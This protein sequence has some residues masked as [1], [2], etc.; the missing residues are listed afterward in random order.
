MSRVGRTGLAFGGTGG[1]GG[2]GGLVPLWPPDF[3]HGSSSGGVGFV[4]VGMLGTSVCIT[5]MMQSFIS[6]ARPAT[7]RSISAFCFGSIDLLASVAH[8]VIDVDTR[9]MHAVSLHAQISSR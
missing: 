3:D 2:A 9:W 7:L 8:E 5:F 4:G 1:T 6:F